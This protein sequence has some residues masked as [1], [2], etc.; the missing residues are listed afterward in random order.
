MERIRLS[1]QLCYIILTHSEPQFAHMEIGTNH[2]YFIYRQDGVIDYTRMYIKN[3]ARSVS[4]LSF[5][6]LAHL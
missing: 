5:S 3:L 2:S 6:F 1:H 4:F